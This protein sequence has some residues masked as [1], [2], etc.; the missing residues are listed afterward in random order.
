MLTNAKAVIDKVYSFICYAL[1]R[2]L[3]EENGTDFGTDFKT[4]TKMLEFEML[5]FIM[6][7]SLTEKHYIFDLF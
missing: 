7:N 1:V 2:F 4:W 5:R 6:F 3:F